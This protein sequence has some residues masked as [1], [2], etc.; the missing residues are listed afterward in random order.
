MTANPPSRLPLTWAVTSQQEVTQIGA[1]GRLA[2]GW[3][4]Y[5]TVSD[6]TVGSVWVPKANYTADS[7]RA[8]VTD[9]VTHVA[10]VSGLTG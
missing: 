8:A 3:K 2:D 7:V 4:V 5:Y 1:D 9:A 6:G 10:A